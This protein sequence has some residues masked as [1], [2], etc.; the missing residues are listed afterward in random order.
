MT[1]GRIYRYEINDQEE[2]SDFAE[3]SY[4][5]LI[6]IDYLRSHWMCLW[7][8]SSLWGTTWFPIKNLTRCFS[9]VLLRKL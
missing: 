5:S 6:N 7:G 2:S 8:R 9:T 4:V 1:E 3:G